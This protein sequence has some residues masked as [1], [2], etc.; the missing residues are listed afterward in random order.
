MQTTA[1]GGA[2]LEK[3]PEIVD[4][5]DGDEEI[6]EDAYDVLESALSGE[7]GSDH[8]VA[9]SQ[10]VKNEVKSGAARGPQ[11]CEYRP[12]QDTRAT[13]EQVLDREQSYFIQAPATKCFCE[14]RGLPLDGQGSE[15]LLCFVEMTRHRGH[16]RRS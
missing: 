7:Y 6:T 16:K 12:C 15:R 11:S 13:T 2:V 4:E 3:E 9:M 8:G 10:Q 14:T 1:N 5:S